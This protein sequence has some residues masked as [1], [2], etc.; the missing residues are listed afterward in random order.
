MMGGNI[1]KSARR[2]DASE[3]DFVNMGDVTKEKGLFWG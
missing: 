1:F 3:D 2:G